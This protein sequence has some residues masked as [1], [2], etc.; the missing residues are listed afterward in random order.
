MGSVSRSRRLALPQARPR[1]LAAGSTSGS[2]SRSRRLAMTRIGWEVHADVLR[3]MHLALPPARPCASCVWLCVR[4]SLA[5]HAFGPVNGSALR[6]VRLA[7]PLAR[8]RSLCVWL[9]LRHGFV[10][11]A[12]FSALP[13]QILGLGYRMDNLGAPIVRFLLCDFRAV[14][15]MREVQVCASRFI[16]K[17]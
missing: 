6:F 11:H 12:S 8:P 15:S 5:L 10:L 4:L 3:F 13:S 2:A 17:V 9:C 14:G 16:R 7:L 1:A